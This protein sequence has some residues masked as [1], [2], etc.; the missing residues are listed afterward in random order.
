MSTV[1]AA[2]IELSTRLND[3]RHAVAEM[4][5]RVP[6]S[7]GAV[8]LA[9]EVTR[10][11]PQ[12]FFRDVLT[13]GGWYRFGGVIDEAG[14]RISDDLAQ[15]AEAEL[16]ARGDDIHV[17][18]DDFAESGHRATRMIGKT[19]YLVASSG[20]LASDFLQIEI[21]ETAGSHQP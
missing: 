12:L 19:H 1:N 7:A 13:R 9:K 14:R 17:L 4:C 15:W 18:A 20:T 10:L 5:V 6:V 3:L 16:A 8:G 2:T 21:E 11:S